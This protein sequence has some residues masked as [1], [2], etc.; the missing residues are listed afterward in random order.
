[1]AQNYIPGQ[2]L[3]S[4]HVGTFLQVDLVVIFKNLNIKAAS[5]SLLKT[6]IK[7]KGGGGQNLKTP[8]PWGRGA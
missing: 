8:N 1:M 2:K 3:S 5:F 7:Q 6:Y 4:S